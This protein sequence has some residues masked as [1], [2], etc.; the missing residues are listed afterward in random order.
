MDYKKPSKEEL[1]K[2][3]TKEQY[4]VTQ[5]AGTERPFQ[6][7]Y[8]SEKRAG[9]YVDVVSGEPL[10]SSEDKYDSGT[11]WPSFSKPIVDE[12]IVLKE[13]KSLF[14]TRTEV[15]SKHGDSHLG[16]VFDDGPR[17]TGKRFCM[18]SASMRFVPAEKLEAEGYGAYKTNFASAS[19]TE[20]RLKRL[21]VAGGCFWYMEGPFEKLDGVLEVRSGYAGGRVA[22]PTYEQVSS[23]TT[24]HR[25]VVEVLYDPEKVAF[26]KLLETY[27]RNVD[28]LDP[29]GQF[30]DQGEQYTTAIYVN[31]AEERKAA[32][33]SLAEL[34][35][36]G[37]LKGKIVTP[38]VD[39]GVFY[40]AEDYHQDYNKK[41][42]LKYRYYR[43]R[44]GRDA[45]LEQ[46]WGAQKH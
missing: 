28:P 31:G 16:H 21:V 13:D 26:P 34:T 29:A 10:F 2:T 15:R 36:S 6:N 43:G 14:G 1:K 25:E 30:C 18:N 22:N 4:K 23:G 3:L 17:P 24:G 33:A 44:C 12:N 32:E 19:K 40:P 8:H 46:L 11:G 38:I 45:R 39:A 9:L 27:W 41:N 20:A 37:V 35:K 7:A 42:P 5:E